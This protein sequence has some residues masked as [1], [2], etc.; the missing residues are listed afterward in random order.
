MS[1][2]LCHHLRR[3]SRPLGFSS[4]IINI[5]KRVAVAAFRLRCFLVPTI[6]SPQSRDLPGFDDV[7]LTPLCNRDVTAV[8]VRAAR[9]NLARIGIEAVRSRFT[10]ASTAASQLA[11]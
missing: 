2:C 1:T 7:R 9:C 3:N 10:L 6:Q 11:A 8:H 4:Q 5:S